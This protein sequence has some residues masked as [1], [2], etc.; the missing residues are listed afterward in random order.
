MNEK[1]KQGFKLLCERYV[2]DLN[3]YENKEIAKD[4]FYNPKYECGFKINGENV[5]FADIL[6]AFDSMEELINGKDVYIA[7]LCNDRAE[8]KEQNKI[9]KE[10]LDAVNDFRKHYKVFLDKLA[11]NLK[12]INCMQEEA[13]TNRNLIASLEDRNDR[14]V[15]RLEKQKA[16]LNDLREFAKLINKGTVICHSKYLS[17]FLTID[18]NAKDFDLVKKVVEKYGQEKKTRVEK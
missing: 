1:V 12:T 16:E 15:E 3:K 8:L 2:K 17:V 7:K 13:T 6:K 4:Y 5:Y 11:N 18:S 14:L 9:L 10:E